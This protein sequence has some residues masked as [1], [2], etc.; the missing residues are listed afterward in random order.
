LDTVTYAGKSAS[1]KAPGFAA[2]ARYKPLH[3]HSAIQASTF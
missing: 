1:E 2:T 3:F